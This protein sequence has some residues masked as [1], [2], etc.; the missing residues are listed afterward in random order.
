MI[1]RPPRFTLFPYT[2]LFRSKPH[3]LAYHVPG[4]TRDGKVNHQ[5]ADVIASLIAAALEQTEYQTNEFGR[6][7]SF[8][9][10]SLVG[11]EQ[12]LEIDR[13]LRTHLAPNGY[14]RHRLLC[15]TSAQFQG[16]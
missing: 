3:V 16:D 5:E 13:L 11:E 4:S 2:T 14:E 7:Y 9:V 15:G 10:V 6:P 8:G 12:A 1:R